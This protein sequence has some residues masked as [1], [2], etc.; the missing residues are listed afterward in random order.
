MFN[1]RT[2]DVRRL[3]VV[4]VATLVFI[5]YSGEVSAAT[6]T[7]DGGGADN[8]WSTDANW[9]GD[10]APS[11][12]D[13]VV[14]D[15][16]SVKNSA[17]DSGL[18]ILSFNASSTYTGALS[19]ANGNTLTVTGNW[20]YNAANFD[21]G[22]STIKF[23]GNTATF[24]P[25][26]VN[27]YNLEVAKPS[28]G[29][30]LNISGT[31]TTTNDLIISAANDDTNNIN[32][33]TVN[34]GRNVSITNANFGGGTATVNMN[35]SG[36]QSV[37]SSGGWLPNF[38]VNKSA[39]TLSLIG[40]VV[41]GGNY[42]HTAG[43]VDAGTS[44]LKFVGGTTTFTPGAVNYYNLEV[45]KP[46]SGSD[47]NIS[48][49]ATTTNDL[50]ISAAND[51]TNNINTGTVN[52]GRNVSITNANFGG[53][54]ATV[55]MN[56]SGSQSVSS[57]G[58]WLPNFSVNKSAGSTTIDSNVRVGG[59]L[60]V[61]AG[62]LRHNAYTLQIDGGTTISSGGTFSDYATAS[63][64]I[65]FG[66]TITN[67]GTLILNGGG[68]SCGDF[69]YVLLRSTAD[70]TQRSWSGSGTFNIQDADLKDMGATSGT[71]TVRS[72]TNSGNNGG[73][74]TFNSNCLP[75]ASFDNDFSS[76][77]S[78]NATVNY[79]LIDPNSDAS[80]I[81][82]TADSGMEYSADGS[83]YSDATQGTGGDG[84]T[85]LS[86]SASPGTSHSFA[87]ASA[88]DLPNTE[89]LT[90][91]LRIRPNDGS[92][93]ASDWATSSAFAIDNV[94]PSSVGAPTFGTI[95]SSSVEIVK[96][97]AVTENGSGLNTWQARRDSATVLS[98]VA[99][100]TASVS[101]SSLSANTQYAYDVRFADYAANA[102]AYG[103]SASKYTLAPTPANL[104]AVAARISI[105]LSVDQFTNDTAGSSGYYFVNSTASTTSGWIQ[106]NFWTDTGL[107][108]GVSYSYTVKH[109][110]G[111]GTETSTVSLDASASACQSETA[112]RVSYAIS[113][114]RIY[115]APKPEKVLPIPASEVYRD[116]ATRI[117]ELQ[118]QIRQ[119]Q[120]R[121]LDL[122]RFLLQ[123]LIKELE[124]RSGRINF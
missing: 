62:E 69:D 17:M 2:S 75:S 98:A 108:C 25:G 61:T 106:A 14:F 118:T 40:T 29:S 30:D 19:I 74:W 9:S 122:Y 86:S 6:R 3:G 77:S 39:G 111:D 22:T 32:T 96:P 34:V 27:Y 105:T 24:T 48:G 33:G 123:A 70:G 23:T 97:T 57:S 71:V 35:G 65:K 81:S 28:S 45:A 4:V 52:V 95:T 85:S 92:E 41:I 38:S 21:A 72:G 1:L 13:D 58:G 15:G 18:T 51:D 16:T 116:K 55:N 73:S 107:T 112:A 100:T 88:T 59:T 10:R 12:N 102:S 109:R 44:T 49:T 20:T 63:S 104:A 94:A 50:I 89:D 110:N 8:N 117:A 31:A 36:S 42:T 60:T 67:N 99:T 124:E 93:N 37:S 82:Q 119:L 121:L 78:G 43:T 101:D 120:A 7:W 64:T 80:N 46:S 91:Y 26:A 84:M 68:T 115:D 53:G 54:T 76:W 47:L 56:G 5:F 114:L 87:W 79:K 66:S 90:V 103:T 11:L 83:T 113:P